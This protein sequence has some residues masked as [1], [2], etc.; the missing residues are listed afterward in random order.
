MQKSRLLLITLTC[1]LLFPVFSAAQ[2]HKLPE[3]VNL[4]D[5]YEKHPMISQDGQ[6]LV[7]LSN[8]KGH[9]DIYVTSKSEN[10]WTEPE[11]LET[12]AS[13]FSENR[14]I[15]SPCFNY[16]ASRIYFSVYP[17]GK[18]DQSDIYYVEKQNGKWSLPKLMPMPVNSPGYEGMPSI[19]AN[20]TTIYFVRN[21]ANIDDKDYEKY[22]C[23]EIFF[24]TLDESGNWS[25]PKKI[26]NPINL[27]CESCPRVLPDNNTLIFSSVRGER[28]NRDGVVIEEPQGDF[29]LYFTRRLFKH[30]WSVPEQMA[31]SSPG[32]DM[33]GSIDLNQERIYFSK[34]GEN[35]KSAI[36]YYETPRK[37]T[38][39]ML[40]VT[41]KITDRFSKEPVDANIDVINPNT[42]QIIS[43]FKAGEDGEYYFTLNKG[44]TYLLDYYKKDYSHSFET[45]EPDTL[46]TNRHENI[47]LELYNKV[48]LLCNVYDAEIYEP[49]NGEITVTDFK[50]SRAIQ[51]NIESLDDGKFLVELPV[52]SRYNIKVDKKH[53]KSYGISLDLS[54]VVQFSNFEKDLEMEQKKKKM[55]IKVADEETNKGMP[56]KLEIT[57]LD[58]NETITKL[59]YQNEDGVYNVELR[60]GDKYEININSQKGY[61]F[62]NKQVNV[63]EGTRSGRMDIKLKPLKEETKIELRNITFETNS[64]ALDAAS[65]KELNRVVGLLKENQNIKIEISAHTD[66]VGS[67]SYNMKLSQRRAQSVVDYL[68]DQGISKDQMV[69]KGYGENKPLL[70]NNSDENRAKNRRVELEILEVKEENNTTNQNKI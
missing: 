8:R 24:S 40:I 28:T 70:P 27:K 19:T 25:E 7:F 41:G 54:G 15:E 51:T 49:I 6:K 37:R 39:N 33:S 47:D 58:K 52:G 5:S 11:M 67:A 12:V 64:A 38:S 50:N 36:Y 60:E 66:D 18:K 3:P 14:I 17:W 16:D 61:S 32:K 69:S 68:L 57:N 10:S 65:Y 35:S 45:L 29:D 42:S 21:K 22:D 13:S 34:D 23:K 48:K 46:K 31:M 26:A 30:I 9:W 55:E 59:A 4:E 53:Y 20:N 2:I 63:G 56:V 44:K 43:R 1:F 62:Y